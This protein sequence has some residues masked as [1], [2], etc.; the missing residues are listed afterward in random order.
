MGAFAVIGALVGLFA[1][2]AQSGRLAL[3]GLIL[4]GVGVSGDGHGNFGVWA[5]I[6]LF[7]GIA[8]LAQRDGRLGLLA[9]A[10]FVF[11]AGMGSAG[12]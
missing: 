9:A 12:F 1:V 11:G 6:G 4:F 3:L 10:T 2:G 8:A 7:L 5:V